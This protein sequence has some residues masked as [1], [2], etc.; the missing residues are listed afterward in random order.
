MVRLVLTVLIEC[1]WF[2]QDVQT[3]AWVIFFE[4][5]KSDYPNYT[6]MRRA[7]GARR[8]SLSKQP[9]IFIC[10][11]TLEM[12]RGKKEEDEGLNQ[13]MS[14]CISGCVMNNPLSLCAPCC[15]TSVSDPWRHWKCI[16]FF[17]FFT[18][19]LDVQI[20]CLYSFPFQVVSPSKFKG[21]RDETISRFINKSTNRWLIQR[22]ATI[23]ITI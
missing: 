7:W 2:C 11:V 5:R 20:N 16:I 19:H 3:Q 9:D 23:L 13:D 15:P 6:E 14:W 12:L 18:W 4:S 21:N 22:M 17:S 8:V 10:P 1:V